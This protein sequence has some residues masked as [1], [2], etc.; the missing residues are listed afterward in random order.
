MVT[1]KSRFAVNNLLTLFS[2]K[3]DEWSTPAEVFRPLDA[4]FQFTLDV[5]ATERNAKCSRYFTREIDGLGEDWSQDIC[6]MNP[7]YSQVGVWMEKAY[8]T[9]LNGAE[10]VCLVPSR[11]DTRWWHS[12]AIKADEIRWIQ[13]RVGFLNPTHR[14]RTRS[15]FPTAV[16]IFRG[17]QEAV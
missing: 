9:S 8:L 10:V 5:A 14:G 1:F 16:V 12:Y 17:S 2:K 11:T 4:E 15:P 3:S 7:P 6:W 13:G